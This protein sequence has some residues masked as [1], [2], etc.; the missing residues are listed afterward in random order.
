MFLTAMGASLTVGAL[1]IAVR[2]LAGTSP[3]SASSA[4]KP[5]VMVW[6]SPTCGCCGGWVDHMRAAGFPVTVQEVNDVEPVK[7]RLGVPARLQSCH[8]ALVGG[9]ALEGH[10]PADSVQR[11]LRERPAAV[12]LAVPGM[13]HGYAGLGPGGEDHADAV[14]FGGAVGG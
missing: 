13:P 11:L 12:G 7:T 10:V 3:A 5:E 6:K 14:L 2:S 8:T 1:A 9:Y 4:A